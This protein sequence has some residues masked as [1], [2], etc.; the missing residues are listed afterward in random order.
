MMYFPI[1]GISTKVSKYLKCSKAYTTTDNS[2]R[3]MFSLVWWE[4][5]GSKL[6]WG[7]W[8][9]EGC[10][11]IVKLNEGKVMVK[12]GCISSWHYVFH[13]CYC[14]VYSILTFININI[15]NCSCNCIFIVFIVCCVSF[16]VCVVLFECDVI[17]FVWCVLFVC[18][19][20]VVPLPP[21]KNPFAV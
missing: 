12:C 20:T 18:C 11:S 15:F 19:L 10:V 3:L 17:Y 14:L 4:G 8:G 7:W 2:L 6:W 1:R 21:G 5:K 16:I 9:C 13:Y